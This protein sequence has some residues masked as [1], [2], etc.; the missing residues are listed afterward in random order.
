MYAVKDGVAMGYTKFDSVRD[1]GEVRERHS[2]S[3]DNKQSVYV[4]ID[5]E[6][7]QI[8]HGEFVFDELRSSTQCLPQ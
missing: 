6:G 1:K 5:L 2:H 3:A 7:R 8:E 4:G